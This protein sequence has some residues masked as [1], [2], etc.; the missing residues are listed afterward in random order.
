[1]G[2]VLWKIIHKLIVSNELN[3][4][5]HLHACIASLIRFGSTAALIMHY[6]IFSS[7]GA[8]EIYIKLERVLEKSKSGALCIPKRSAEIPIVLAEEMAVN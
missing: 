6:Y 8:G 5:E 4:S 7:S 1:M 3:S 2:D